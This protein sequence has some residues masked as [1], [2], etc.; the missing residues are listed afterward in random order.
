MRP[1]AS[2]VEQNG[3]QNQKRD[4]MLPV[5]KLGWMAGV[6]DTKA[7]IQ[8][9]NN[10]TR[11]TSQI[12]IYVRTM[13]HNVVQELCSLT[14]IRP[15]YEE[16]RS[17]KEW[18]RRACSQHCPEAHVHI[19]VGYEGYMPA[20]AEWMISGAALAVVIYNIMP[21]L[22]DASKYLPLIE[23]LFAN[24]VLTG[25]GR[26]MTVSSI[27]RLHNMG[28]EI[29]VPLRSALEDINNESPDE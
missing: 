3:R 14:G 13:N 26:G 9:I 5:N 4:S 12:R 6:I 28:W 2:I 17:S 16:R 21:F 25:Q 23:E 22:T 10:K 18:M 19:S 1:G 20:M 7:R 27:R 29:P 15:R 11:A 24:A 8:H